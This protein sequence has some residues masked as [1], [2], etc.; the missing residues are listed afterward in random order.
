M[1]ML[2]TDP[3]FYISYPNFHY[4]TII[5]KPSVHVLELH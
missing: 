3:I 2:T 5:S 4:L 1:T